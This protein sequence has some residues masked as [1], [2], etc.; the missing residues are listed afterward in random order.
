METLHEFTCI[1]TVAVCVAGC[2]SSVEKRMTTSE[3][4]HKVPVGIWATKDA[5][6]EHEFLFEG[7]AVYLGADGVGAIVG[8]P[9]PIGSRIEGNFD[10]HGSRFAFRMTEQGE[11]K[12]EGKLLYDP[13]K[14]TMVMEG[15]P[16]T[17][18]HRRFDELTDSVRKK[19]GLEPTK[20]K[21]RTVKRDDC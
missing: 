4:N 8:G 17:V 19:L 12:G 3:A 21:A 5:V 10:T 20:K 15:Q 7:A 11:V 14:D 9:P 1:F 2:S 16:E 6:F 18:M 13:V